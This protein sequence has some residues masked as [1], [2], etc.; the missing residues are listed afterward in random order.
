MQFLL[1]GDNFWSTLLFILFFFLYPK[2]YI[3]QMIWKL[4]SDL[5]ELEYYYLSSKKYVI[6]KLKD[7]S[8]KT[9]KK[10]SSFM[11]FVISFP[12]DIEPINL[13]NKIEHILNR[14][15]YR[16]EYFVDRVYNTEDKEDKKNFK[17]ALIGATGTYQL[18][19]IIRHY[20]LTIKKT[21]NLQLA[22]ILQMSMPLILKLA[23]ANMRATEAFS[24]QIP[25][26]D[27]IG[28]AVAAQLKTKDGI[29]IAKGIVVS[30]EKVFNREVYVMKAKGPGAELGKIAEAVRKAVKK[31]KINHIITIDAAAKLEGEKTG[32]TAQGVGVMMGGIGVERHRIEELAVEHNIPLDGIIIKM[33]PEEASIHMKKQIWEAR[34]K[35]ILELE[36]L[37]N[38]LDKNKKV[39]IIGVG[40]TCGI[41]NKKKDLEEVDAKLKK[42]WAK[43]RRNKDWEDYFDDKK[44]KRSRK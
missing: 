37:L 9:K 35:A 3:M 25:I 14:Y 21:N 19:K 42:I 15:E 12:V 17:Y 24:K 5:K 38:S 16:F 43:L 6:D 23:K 36:D 34:D 22:M 40:N 1:F 4:E 13:V 30:K 39:L 11:E 29:E 32:S 8:S 26:G 18:Y 20:I 33:S 10:I 31:Y 7:K 27:S 41:G 44:G 2:L 28:P